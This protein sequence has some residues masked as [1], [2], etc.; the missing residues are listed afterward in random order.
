M[1]IFLSLILLAMFFLFAIE[2]RQTDVSRLVEIG[3]LTSTNPPKPEERK[4]DWVAKGGERKNL[5]A[6]G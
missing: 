1:I 3:L 2:H 4:A 5:D 6:R